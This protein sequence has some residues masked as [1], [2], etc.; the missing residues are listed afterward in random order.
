M[1]ICPSY[2]HIHTLSFFS[3][4]GLFFVTHIYTVTINLSSFISYVV[5]W[6]HIYM[7]LTPSTKL[8]TELIQCKYD[9]PFRLTVSSSKRRWRQKRRRRRRK[10]NERPQ[11][12]RSPLFTLLF[13]LIE[14]HLTHLLRIVSLF[15]SLFFLLCLI[16]R[17][18]L[19]EKKSKKDVDDDDDEFL[20]MQ[21]RNEYI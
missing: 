8:M 11:S 19:N 16:P 20:F 2:T 3:Y 18:C 12:V 5:W 9:L 15:R 13:K 1:Y 4:A 14:H 6:T 21:S 7:H 10:I 17:R